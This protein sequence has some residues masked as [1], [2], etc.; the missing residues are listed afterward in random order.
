MASGSLFRNVARSCV[1]A[2]ALILPTL[3]ASLAEE[4]TVRR[5]AQGPSGKDIQIGLYLN[6]LANCSSGTLPSIQMVTPPANGTAIVKRAKVALTNYKNCM[7][8]EVPAFIGIYRSK[9]DFAGS[10]RLTLTISYP[11]GRT[12]TQEIEITVGRKP[13]GREI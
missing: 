13:G 1:L 5:T 7:A 6:V 3:Q 8:L 10:D 4:T 11:N 2:A 9:P 12:E